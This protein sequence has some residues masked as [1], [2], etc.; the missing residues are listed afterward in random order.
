MTPEAYLALLR[1]P[2]GHRSAVPVRTYTAVTRSATAEAFLMLH[3]KEGMVH[4]LPYGAVQLIEADGVDGTKL[5]L[6]CVKL[7]ITVHGR[8]LG[9]VL[10]AIRTRTA[11][12]IREYSGGRYDPP[13]P[14]EAVIMEC[15]FG[16]EQ[17]RPK[18]VA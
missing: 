1:P 3:S 2:A 13:E 9:P 8:Q 14:G 17:A 10:E 6:T 4:A 16:V 15:S 5:R 18:T 7:A 11:A 12:H